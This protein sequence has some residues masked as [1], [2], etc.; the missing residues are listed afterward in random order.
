[1]ASRNILWVQE[2]FEA[3]SAV[4]RQVNEIARRW[5]AAVEL[6]QYRCEGE[7]AD[8]GSEPVRAASSPVV[9]AST[10]GVQA[11]LPVDAS[12]L[13]D[14]R[15]HDTLAA[16]VREGRSG[17]GQTV[18]GTREQLL[19]AI[20]PTIKYSLVAVGDLFLLEPTAARVRMTLE[21]SDFL[22]RRL[23]APVVS[24]D[25]AGKSVRLD[26]KRWLQRW[27]RLIR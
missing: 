21:L 26:P 10:Q 1:M 20:N 24:T 13:R 19:S 12:S 2:N 7:E 9:K 23:E 4:F 25:A 16:L 27:R 22:A 11:E 18:C 3:D 17:G 15:F 5:G 14:K 8:R 6:L